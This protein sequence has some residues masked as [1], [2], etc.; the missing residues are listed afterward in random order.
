MLSAPQY[1]TN[2]Q[3]SVHIGTIF[4][5]AIANG[6]ENKRL[7]KSENS[8]VGSNSI[9]FA[10]VR[11]PTLYQSWPLTSAMEPLMHGRQG[12]IGCALGNH[13]SLEMMVMINLLSLSTLANFLELSLPW[14][15]LLVNVIVV[16]WFFIMWEKVTRSF[17][18]CF[19]DF[20]DI[21]KSNSSI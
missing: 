5:G 18:G 16:S 20:H 11:H 13:N 21:G 17:N 12:I 4:S 10:K 19:P 2:R 1:V 3:A 15:K 8:L 7:P 14:K 9:S 6:Q